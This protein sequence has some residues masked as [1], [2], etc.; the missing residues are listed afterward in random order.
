[1]AGRG[2]DPYCALP[3]LS[4][5][6]GHKTVKATEKYVRMT[7]ESYQEIVEMEQSLT[8]YVYPGINLKFETD[9]G[10]N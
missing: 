2:F 9:Y 8:S 7:R 6:L 1:M 4:A 10:Y 3:V 5:F